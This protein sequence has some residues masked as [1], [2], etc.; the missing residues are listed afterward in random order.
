MATSSLTTG[1]DQDQEQGAIS[2][3]MESQIKVTEGLLFHAQAMG[4][5]SDPQVQIE[6][7]KWEL[8]L[9]RELDDLRRKKKEGG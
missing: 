3:H 1:A 7:A 8:R 4:Q 9:E 2:C 5:T 6:A